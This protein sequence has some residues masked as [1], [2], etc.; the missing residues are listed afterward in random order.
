MQF[1]FTISPLLFQS[2]LHGRIYDSASYSGATFHIC[3]Y[4]IL[5]EKALRRCQI[6]HKVRNQYVRFS[7][8]E[9]D[10]TSPFWWDDSACYLGELSAGAQTVRFV[11]ILTGNGFTLSVPHELTLQE[12]FN[13][14]LCHLNSHINSY[15]FKYTDRYLDNAKTLSEN[16]ILWEEEQNL[17]EL[18]IDSEELVP[19]IYSHFV[20]DLTVG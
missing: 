19:T 2:S 16:G 13:E 10:S 15:I 18:A 20:D 4:Q 7:L 1:R 11:N 12:I 6:L 14:H 8:P 3:S 17:A 5:V 9:S